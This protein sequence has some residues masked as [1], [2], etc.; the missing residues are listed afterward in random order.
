MIGALDGSRP[1]RR[2][3]M[4]PS[5]S[6]LMVQP[7]SFAQRTNRSRPIL[8]RSVSAMRQTAALLGPADLAELHQARPQA[9]GIDP[10]IGAVGGGHGNSVES[11]P[12]SD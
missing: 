5:W 12:L 4:L 2:A 3:K 6:T 9:V 10:E 11:E 1:S 8:S 7:A